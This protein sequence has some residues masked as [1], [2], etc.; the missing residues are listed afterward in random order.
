MLSIH[1]LDPIDLY[2]MLLARKLFVYKLE[3]YIRDFNVL[4]IIVRQS[5]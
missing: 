2:L 3:N 1:L 4:S 5:C